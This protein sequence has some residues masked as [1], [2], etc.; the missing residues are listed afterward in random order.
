MYLLIIFFISLLLT[1][2][3]TPFFIEY[4]TKRK[5]ID[6]PGERRINTSAV[7]RMGGL[8]IYLNTVLCVISFYGNLNEIR[9]FILGSA[10]LLIA[11]VIDDIKELN[12]EKKF[13]VQFITGMLLIGF[14]SP[15]YSTITLFGFTMP[16]GIDKIILLIFIVGVINAINLYDG[17][18]GLVTGFSLLITF[19]AFLIGWQT[20]NKLLLILSATL[21]GSLLGF[22]K[23]NAFPARIFLGDSGSLTLGFFLVTAALISSTDTRTKNIDL[24][25]SILLLGVPVIDT[26][27][28]MVVRF[29][30][31]KN[32]FLPDKSH[33]HHI[34]LGS[35]IKHKLTVF[36]LQAFALTFA[37]TALYYQRYSKTTGIIIFIVLAVLLLAIK[38]LLLLYKRFGKYIP[39]RQLYWKFPQYVITF[40][41]R[42]LLPAFSACSV[43]ILVGL[44]PLN[45]TINN[46]LIFL[47]LIFVITLLGFSVI[48]LHKEKK[49]SDILVFFNFIIFLI[50]S[51]Y[52]VNISNIFTQLGIRVFHPRALLIYVT[53]PVIVFFLFFRDRLMSKKIILFTGIDLI[54]A[55]FIVLFSISSTLLPTSPEIS[56]LNVVLFHSFLLYIFYKIITIVK[57]QYQ[58][59]LYYLSF[60]IPLAAL[61]RLLLH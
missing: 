29:L 55:V 23:Y 1:V 32:I 51:N 25:F 41:G 37:V 7:P 14:L 46:F 57:I 56:T 39:F 5:I 17:L 28:V 16:S 19:V 24:T 20:G 34:I 30:K 47:S 4:F 33:V 10:L 36:I 42:F 22:L 49:I 11:G 50:Y 43:L 13:A 18:D 38:K 21:I 59:L 27:K 31:R 53:L 48:N 52:S 2:F 9:F 12:P 40:F 45:S 58:P 6:L 54:I 8:I 61:I 26:L 60:V 35:D 15:G 44:M 3:F